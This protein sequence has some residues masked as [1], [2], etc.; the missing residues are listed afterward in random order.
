MN[1]RSAVT[2]Y[3]F[4][5]AAG[6]RGRHAGHGAVPAARVAAR[7]PDH[8]GTPAGRHPLAAAGRHAQLLRR[9]PR[10]AAALTS[11]T[12][13]TSPPSQASSNVRSTL[14]SHPKL[15]RSTMETFVFVPLTTNVVLFVRLGRPDRC[16]LSIACRYRPQPPPPS[17]AA[18]ELFIVSVTSDPAPWKTR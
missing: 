13:S 17:L 15:L 7:L 2:M 9:R 10:A 11:P 14:V 18:N 3:F 16:T 4:F 8:P 12:A 6:G 5:P 1:K